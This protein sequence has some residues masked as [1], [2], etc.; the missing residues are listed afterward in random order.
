[1]Q[2]LDEFLAKFPIPV[3]VIRTEV[4][5]GLIRARLKGK[6]MWCIYSC[7]DIEI[8]YISL[9]LYLWILWIK[10][11]IDAFYIYPL[12]WVRCKMLA[13][14]FLQVPLKPRA[15]WS[16]SWTLI[17]RPQKAGLNLWWQKYIKTGNID[18]S[19]TI[20]FDKKNNQTHFDPCIIIP[21]VDMNEGPKNIKRDH[22]SWE[23]IICAGKGCVF[24]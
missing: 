14:F 12:R 4:R 17:V 1:M 6:K 15:R 19:P 3:Y 5:T 22:N 11:Q 24:W 23:I 18:N 8:F 9:V 20:S 2:P 21:E 16:H 13:L 7:I 10:K